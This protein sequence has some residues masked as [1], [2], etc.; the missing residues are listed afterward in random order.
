MITILISINSIHS[1]DESFLGIVINCRYVNVT[2]LPT[3]VHIKSPLPFSKEI[4][5]EVAL[6][7]SSK[8]KYGHKLLLHIIGK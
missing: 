3:L 6:L 1:D 8:K 4:P 2:Y 7:S 5:I